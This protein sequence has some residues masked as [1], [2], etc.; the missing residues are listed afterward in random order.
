MIAA[1][2]SR[3]QKFSDTVAI[4]EVDAQAQKIYNQ[5]IPA[6]AGTGEVLLIPS[7]LENHEEDLKTSVNG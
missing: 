7:I 5:L 4:I 6:F 3:V 1:G 2:K